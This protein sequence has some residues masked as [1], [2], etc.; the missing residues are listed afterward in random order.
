ML[1][2]RTLGYDVSVMSHIGR[3]IFFWSIFVEII[4][5][6]SPATSMPQ[7][8]LSGRI[9]ERAGSG[10][11][12][13]MVTA[14]G[15]DTNQDYLM[16]SAQT[17]E[18]GEFAM[19]VG[20]GD[21]T[22]ESS[23]SDL[24]TAGY[25]S[26]RSRYVTVGD[27]PLDGI[28]FVVERYQSVTRVMGSVIGEHGES[29]PNVYVQAYQNGFSTSTTANANGEFTFPLW[30]GTWTFS[31]ATS[32]TEY[33]TSRLTY[34][35]AAGMEATKVVLIGW[36]PSRSLSGIIRNRDG[37]PASQAHITA[38]ATVAGTN[39][40]AWS[41]SDTNGAY[42]LGLFP[43]VWQIYGYYTERADVVA[44]VQFVNQTA[45][46]AGTNV[47]LDLSPL[48][49]DLRVTG[50]VID[51]LGVGLSNITVRASSFG[52]YYDEARAIT[53]SNGEFRINL[54]PDKWRFELED[55]SSGLLAPSVFWKHFT[56]DSMETNLTFVV[57][58]ST[59]TITG[60][61]KTSTGEP[62][63]NFSIY[64]SLRMKPNYFSARGRTDCD[65]QFVLPVFPGIWQVSVN[66]FYF[67]GENFFQSELN[68][69][70]YFRPQ[71]PQVV[72]SGSNQTV[73]LIAEKAIL[74]ASIQGTFLD[75]AGVPLA[76]ADVSVWSESG[77]FIWNDWLRTKNDGTFKFQLPE[78][79]WQLSMGVPE[80]KTNLF[81]PS[82]SVVLTGSALETNLVLV[83]RVS[84][85]TI[86]GT[87]EDHLGN[88][89]ANTQYIVFAQVD[90]IDYVTLDFA[91]AGGQFSVRVFPGLWACGM[92]GLSLN[93][94]GFRSVPQTN[95]TVGEMNSTIRFI[96][97]PITG[98]ARAGRLTSIERLPGGEIQI[99]FQSQLS[100]RYI[101][102]ASANLT[103]WSAV[104][105]NYPRFGYFTYLPPTNAA[106]S[107]YRAVSAD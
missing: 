21:W 84:N 12:N 59:A 4:F 45:Q 55:V 67:S 48:A 69:R 40:S 29:L 56:W 6:A 39:Y 80:G 13:I 8:E 76:G 49:H 71:E 95:I 33:F 25:R 93:D 42:S 60:T 82:V 88:R 85:R 99:E 52:N 35:I 34:S 68:N 22:V 91:D 81:P 97:S 23:P 46:V 26:G 92:E 2:R 96:T 44:D 79:T 1:F 41:S 50:R 104:H 30:D 15:F 64:A 83:A 105:T 58:H 65:G 3:S 47:M 9:S 51:D 61:L 53:S 78:G 7:I 27:C 107:F 87:V 19:L 73:S 62:L 24:A 17:D 10:V 100:A 77:F 31:F 72:V 101:I 5:A 94:M 32:S 14:Y 63:R 37:T 20:A 89:I 106:H 16:F 18:R 28:N 103:D 102:E 38:D 11:S 43:A 75:E 70:G 90:G 36:M 66:D 54:S 86:L 74:S 98:N 57:Y